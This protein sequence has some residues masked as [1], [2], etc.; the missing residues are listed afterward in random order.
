MPAVGDRYAAAGRA[1]VGVKADVAARRVTRFAGGRQQL[2]RQARRQL[3]DLAAGGAKTM[4]GEIDVEG[5]RLIAGN[6]LR[7][8]QS[9]AGGQ[10]CR[11]AAQIETAAD[12]CAMPD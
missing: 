2:D 7:A 6:R 5:D 1:A 4:R 9:E 3:L 8:R 12:R 11:R 10:G